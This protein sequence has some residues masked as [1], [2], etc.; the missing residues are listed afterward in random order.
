MF[1]DPSPENQ[2]DTVGSP[3]AH[4]AAKNHAAGQAVYID[5]IPTIQSECRE[6]FV[7]SQKFYEMSAIH[8]AVRSAITALPINVYDAKKLAGL[9]A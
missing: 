7:K 5:D 6:S 4:L 9:Q 2:S 1:E 3:M 8:V